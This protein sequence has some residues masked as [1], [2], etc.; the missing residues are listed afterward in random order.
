MTP[1]KE[2]T[3]VVNSIWGS[4]IYVCSVVLLDTFVLHR[5]DILLEGREDTVPSTTYKW[6][7][8]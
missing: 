2:F 6:V 1:E 7:M 5:L 4:I 3:K 8:I